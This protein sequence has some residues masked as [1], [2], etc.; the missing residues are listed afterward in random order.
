MAILSKLCLVSNLIVVALMADV[1]AQVNFDVSPRSLSDSTRM[2]TN[3]SFYTIAHRGASAYAP[4]N[5]MV[6]FYKAVQMNADMLE[7]DVQLSKD[8]KI[9]VFHDADLKK[10]TNGKGKVRDFTYAELE[11]LDAGSWFNKKFKSERIPLLRDVL[12]YTK[13]KIL[14]NIEIKT[15]AV[16]EIVDGGITSLVLQLID[17]L[18]IVDQVIISSFDYRVLER[19]ANSGSSVKRALLYNKKLSGKKSPIELVAEYKADAFNCSARE[20]NKRWISELS[21]KEIPFFVYTVNSPRK[22]EKLIKSGA[23]GIF[24]DKPDVLK[25][26]F[27]SFN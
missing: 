6:A 20:L 25:Q 13:D 11:K 10:K 21:V 17:E 8:K 22:M 5:T 19:L 15:E 24:S 2:N 9:V 27:D 1:Y 16:T 12:T 4:E 18:E 26:V 3:K 14:V 7:L 23:K